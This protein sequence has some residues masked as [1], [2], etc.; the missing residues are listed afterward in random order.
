[1][2]S[3]KILW[4]V[5]GIVVL[6]SSGLLLSYLYLMP[7]PETSGPLLPPHDQEP[8]VTVVGVSPSPVSPP[9]KC[10]TYDEVARQIAKE[11]KN[12]E[13]TIKI[14]TLLSINPADKTITFHAPTWEN[15]LPYPYIQEPVVWLLDQKIKD[16]QEFT[17]LY[18]QILQG[19]IVKIS[20]G[21]FLSEQKSG[22]GGEEF[23]RLQP[24]PALLVLKRLGQDFKEGMSS[25]S[26]VILIIV[27][28]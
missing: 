25:T 27:G 24:K 1:M 16:P 17:T 19:E 6:V 5:L 15:P 3:Q 23:L 7:L 4:I 8:L 12:P 21:E 11:R 13:F 2:S 22:L 10:Y 26:G 20:L 28:K 18:S 14:G 9:Q